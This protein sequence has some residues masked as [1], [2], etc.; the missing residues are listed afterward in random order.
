MV[1]LTC[2]ISGPSGQGE[3]KQG[4]KQLHSVPLHADIQSQ[5]LLWFHHKE[6][7]CN[8]LF[9]FFISNTLLTQALISFNK[10]NL[11]SYTFTVDSFLMD[12]TIRWTSW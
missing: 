4:L 6:E 10:V 5:F 12:T 7:N 2:A 11:L 1:Y 9:Y 8:C 3:L